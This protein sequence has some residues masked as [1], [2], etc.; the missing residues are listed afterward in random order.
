MQLDG[1]EYK[2][3]APGGGLIQDG[4]LNPAKCAKRELRR[5]EVV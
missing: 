1:K 4:G 2:C 3:H 5:S